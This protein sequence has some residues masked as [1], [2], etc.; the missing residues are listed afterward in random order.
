[1]VTGTTTVGSG[2]FGR[3]NRTPTMVNLI[4][5]PGLALALVMASLRLP[6]PLSLLLVTV[7]IAG[8]SRSSR[9][10]RRGRKLG[11]GREAASGRP[12]Q[13]RRHLGMRRLMIGS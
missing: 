6:A 4:V 8:A 5:L 12:N 3:M 13:R 11:A 9:H 2:V 1:M 10:S 7:N